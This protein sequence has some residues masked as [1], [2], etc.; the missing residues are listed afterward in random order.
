MDYCC[1]LKEEIMAPNETSTERAD[2]EMKSETLIEK[3]KTIAHGIFM[4]K[5]ANCAEAVFGAIQEIVE[6]DFPP[7]V[8]RLMTPFGGGV[9]ISGANCGAMLGGM[10]A[11]A[12]CYG[13]EDS[14]E[15][16]LENHRRHLWKTYALYNQLP[17]RFRERFG[18]IECRDLTKSHIYGT[19]N[20]RDFCENVVAETAGLVM[21]LLIEAEE[22]GLNFRFKKSILEQGAKATGLTTEDLID[23]KAKAIPFPIKHR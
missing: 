7:E 15:K 23:H 13:R 20:C 2:K 22:K 11:L 21:E 14:H 5:Q 10:T 18:T 12:L 8:S 9:G 3:A 4:D 19:K 16:S 17:H 1:Y 6:N